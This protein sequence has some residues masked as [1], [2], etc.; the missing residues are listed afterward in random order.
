MNDVPTRHQRALLEMALEV[1]RICKKHHI[2]YQLFAGSA[3]GAVRHGGFIPWDDDLDLVM[4][5]PAYERFL[6]VAPGEL[7]PER[8]YLQKEFSPHWPMFFT[9]LRQ[10]NTACMERFRP[11]DPAMHQGIYIDIFPCDNLSDRPVWARLQFAASKLVIARS[12]GRR[13]YLTRNPG[14]KLLIGLSA[15]LPMKPLI[16]FVENRSESGSGQV[17][18]FFGASS[19]YARSVFPRAWLTES[20]E[21]PFQSAAFPVSAFSDALL[22]RLYGNWHRIPTPEERACKVH[23]QIVDL[24]RPYTAYLEEQMHM[25]IKTYSR[26]IR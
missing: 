17:H 9:K 4:L 22:T 11:K 7:D 15:L 14:K 3:L 23:G 19:R 16:R 26:S 13:G 5:R 10:N 25:D 18:T 12:L 6:A 24:D 8:Y 2:A 20:R 21:A 1:D